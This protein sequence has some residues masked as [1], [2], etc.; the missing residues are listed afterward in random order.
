MNNN[1]FFKALKRSLS[2]LFVILIL[3]PSFFTISYADENSNTPK[4]FKYYDNKSFCEFAQIEMDETYARNIFVANITTGDVMFEKDPK[5]LIYPASTVKIMTAIVAY[6]NIPDLDVLIYAS[7]KAIKK[8]TG[9]KLN[10]TRPIKV[11]EGLSARDLLYGLLV[12]GANDAANVLAEY[13]GGTEENFVKMMNDKA[14]EIGAKY[15]TF[16]NPTGLHH[17]DMTT[18]AY[19]MALISNYAYYINDIV[20]MSGSPNHTIEETNITKN[21]RSLYN[22]NR[23]IRRVEGETNYF[24][25]GAIG[26]SAGSTPEGGNCVIALAEKSGQT[27]LAVVMNADST[28]TENYAYSDAKKLLNVCFNNFSVKKVAKSGDI[29]HEIPVSL[30]ASVDHVILHA[31]K[32]ISALLPNDVDMEKDIVLKKLVYSDAVAPVSKNQIFGELEVIYKGT[33]MLGKT[34][35]AAGNDVDRSNLLY[36]LDALRRFFT[37]PWFITALITAIILFAVYC[38][39][40]YKSLRGNRNYRRYK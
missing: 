9:T 29:H 12:T 31:A 38:Y 20:K 6:E 35:L 27:Y 26:L 40:Y 7:E 14:K 4:P 33:I 21:R 34:D 19:D 25:K 5:M 36:F 30:A 8:T 39:L 28:K 15:T 17:P 2:F 1:T 3:L 37:S 32:D 23:M 22:R 11:G 10:P 16:K 24:F 13:V 18:T